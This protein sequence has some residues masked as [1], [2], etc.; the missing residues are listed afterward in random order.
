MALADRLE[1]TQGQAALEVERAYRQ[2]YELCHQLEDSPLLNRVLIGLFV[3]TL[4]QGNFQQAR[5]L[6]T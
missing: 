3:V 5:I 1:L 4:T 6:G 2:A